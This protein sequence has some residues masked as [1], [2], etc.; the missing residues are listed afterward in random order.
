M[1]VNMKKPKVPV[2]PPGVPPGIPA[3]SQVGEVEPTTYPAG[4]SANRGDHKV[5]EDELKKMK[6]TKR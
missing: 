3:R 6:G 4:F 5:L 2:K 1:E